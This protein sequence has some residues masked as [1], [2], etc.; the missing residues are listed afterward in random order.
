[1][2]DGFLAAANA[3][4]GDKTPL[5]KAPML[6]RHATNREGEDLAEPLPADLD[7][8]KAKITLYGFD[9]SPPCTKVKTLFNFYGVEYAFLSAQ[10][11]TK[12]DGLPDPTYGKVPKLVIEHAGETRQINDS[13]V[14]FRALSPFLTGEPL[15]A[16]QVEL[17]KDNNILGFMGA[18][19]KETA[20][21]YRGIVRATWAMTA[22][23]T[24]TL[25]T[26][27]VRPWMP[28]AVGLLSLPAFALFSTVAPHGKHGS[29][30]H[31]GA[32]FRA[33]LGEQAFFHGAKVGPLDLSLYGTLKTFVTM[34]SPYAIAVLDKCELRAWFERVDAAVEAIKPLTFTMGASV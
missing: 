18:L 31:F 11:G 29:S 16:A 5:K 6:V 3:R 20:S 15:N 8:H 22:N 10:P 12:P 13:A 14:I 21:S 33:A 24:G 28:Y 19:E 2:S 34:D 1:M 9:L 4:S 25:S 27:L 32:K 17:E 26:Y 23:W 30:L 7:L